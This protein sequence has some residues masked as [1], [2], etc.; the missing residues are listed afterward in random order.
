MIIVVLI[1]G[2]NF[3]AIKIALSAIPPLAF[4]ALRFAIGS[5]AMALVLWWRGDERPLPRSDVWKLI[6]LGLL[7]NTIYQPLFVYG[8]SLT[9]AANSA[10]IL[11]TS[12]V[13]VASFGALAGL[14]RITRQVLWGLALAV[15]G[16]TLVVAAR[17]AT[18][19]WQTVGGD[20]LV[21]ASVFC[22]AGYVLGVRS[23]GKRVSSLR[24]TALTT[25]AGTPGLLLVG[26][27][28]MFGTD[29]RQVGTMA[30]LGLL[31]AALMALVV[32]YLLYNRSVRLVG[33]IH[34]TIYACITPV[35]A[36]LIAWPALGEQPQPLQAAGAVL[37]IAGVLLVRRQSNQNGVQA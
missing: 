13:I 24:V 30:W 19:S 15:P 20:L 18:L 2:A 28:E 22:W 12:P 25:I 29:W 3:T 33:G 37:I 26:A 31:Y 35:V 17:G 5:V 8:L 14:E 10:L 6:W 34:T 27:P 36:V 1:W 23:L 11:A 9:T 32:A 4:M 7:G 21:L 16:I